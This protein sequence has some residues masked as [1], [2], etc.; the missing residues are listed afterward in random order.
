MAP[1]IQ[2]LKAFAVVCQF[3]EYMS[4]KRKFQEKCPNAVI[5][6]EIKTLSMGIEQVPNPLQIGT[7]IPRQVI[8]ISWA[9]IFEEKE[10]VLILKK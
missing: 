9:I 8:M 6:E 7:T 10:T 3:Q 1:K 5:V 4:E 2:E